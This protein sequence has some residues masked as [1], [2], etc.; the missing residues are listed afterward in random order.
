M[1]QSNFALSII[2]LDNLK[3]YVPFT[4]RRGWIYQR[5]NENPYIEKGQT[6]QLIKRKRKNKQ[7]S[8]KQYT[9]K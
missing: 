1:K 2:F 6:T 4:T 5:V 9:E 3:I 8:T 7:R